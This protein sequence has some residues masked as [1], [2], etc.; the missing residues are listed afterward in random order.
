MVSVNTVHCRTWVDAKTSV[1]SG[2]LFRSSP[3]GMQDIQRLIM[4][5]GM[6]VT[7]QG[8]REGLVWSNVAHSAMQSRSILVTCDV[9]K[10][11]DKLLPNMLG[12]AARKES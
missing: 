5:R 9:C 12:E 7:L 10:P 2:K 1:H 6:S 3:R 8:V 11:D 4:W